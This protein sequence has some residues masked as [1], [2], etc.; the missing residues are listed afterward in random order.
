MSTKEFILRFIRRYPFHII[1]NIILGFAGGLFN[2][3]NTALIVPILL[4]I[5][6]QE[7][8]LKG[9]PPII[10]FLLSPFDGV[11]EKY[12]LVVMLLAVILTIILKNLTTYLKN[13]LSVAFTRSLTNSIKS[14]MF[15]T[16]MDSDLDFFT[17]VKVGDLTKRLGSD[18]AQC[19]QTINAYINI[20]TQS[21]TILLFVSI[22]ISISW[23]LTL[24]STLLVTLIAGINQLFIR[25]SKKFGSLLN[26][27]QKTYAIKVIETLSGIRLIKSV[28]SENREYKQLR[29]LMLSLEDIA[30][31]AKM[32]S[33][34]IAPVNE[35]TSIITVISIL[36]LGR[37]LF[38]DQMAN[39]SAILLTY[40]LVL[41]RSLPMIS[42]IN[43]TRNQIA[44]GSASFNMALDLWR[45]D[46]KPIM[47]PGSIPFQKVRRK[48][49]FNKISFSYPGNSNLVL[50][51]VDVSVP[52]GKTLALVGGSGAGKSTFA[53]LLPR[54][55]DPISGS[56]TIDGIDLREFDI[57]SLRRKTGIVSQT[58][59]LFNDTVRN[60]IF[61]ACP[62]ATEDEMIQAAKQANAYDFIMELPKQ[63]ETEIGDR[64]VMLSG[65][66]R[67][68]LA[69]ARALLQDP[70]ILILDEAT[71]AL[72][73]VSERLVQEAI[74]KLSRDRTVLVIAHRLSTIQNADQIAVLERGELVEIG[75]HLELLEKE[76]GYYRRLYSIQFGDQSKAD[77]YIDHQ[78]LTKASYEA[79]GSLNQII[80]SLRLLADE[81]VDTPEEQTE[82]TEEAFQSAI[83]LLRTLEIFENQMVNKKK[84]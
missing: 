27:E 29:K 34:L 49:H 45:R 50:K 73:T 72:D 80:G 15:Q 57:T 35:V 16:L 12:R 64:G 23:Q 67:Q 59:H 51:N 4:Q 61:Y 65:G 14:E 18:T 52:K 6:G 22:L 25:R 19:T 66:Q 30:L 69:I 41:F 53:D 3:V 79:R 81:I 32:N 28:S 10:Q 33:A 48:I 47:K 13:L 39:V 44:K 56:I 9:S 76:D 70:E 54:F 17:K 55:Y 71:S 37:T 84:V 2:G 24:I 26:R 62:D 60:N 75:T 77:S 63:W 43:G 20:V 1:G 68:R 36:L 8:E 21:I 40:L 78:L 46:N 7:I 82:L 74:D 58:T 5:S 31:R 83:S 11:P 38:A 42:G